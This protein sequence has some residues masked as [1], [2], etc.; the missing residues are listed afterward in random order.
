MRLQKCNRLKNATRRNA[1][2]KFVAMAKIEFAG[3]IISPDHL[4]T[5]TYQYYFIAIY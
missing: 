5:L 4:I 3:L 2:R 1:T